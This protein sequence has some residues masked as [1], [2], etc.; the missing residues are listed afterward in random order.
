MEVTPFFSFFVSILP[1]FLWIFTGP[2]KD[3][4]AKTDMIR[5]PMAAPENLTCTVKW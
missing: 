1:S 4:P 2:K 3:S 5:T